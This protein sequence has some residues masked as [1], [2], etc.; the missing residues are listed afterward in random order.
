MS[1]MY[2]LKTTHT[3]Q[4]L[5]KIW[6]I[7]FSQRFTCAVPS[8][9]TLM[10]ICCLDFYCH[11]WLP[12]ALL[13]FAMTS[14]HFCGFFHCSMDCAKQ[15]SVSSNFC[16]EDSVIPVFLVI[17]CTLFPS[18]SSQWSQLAQKRPLLCCS[19]RQEVMCPVNSRQALETCHSRMSELG[20][21]Q[22]SFDL[23][24]LQAWS[25]PWRGLGC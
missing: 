18:S 21:R 15:L 11:R 23:R 22:S 4:Q 12:R 24:W 2:K 19:C 9:F 20:S 17:F 7:S 10:N 14:V 5:N 16:C 13:I 3:H 6:R 8:Q 25:T 1:H